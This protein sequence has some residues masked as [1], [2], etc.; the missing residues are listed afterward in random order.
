VNAVEW[1]LELPRRFATHTF[2]V[3]GVTGHTLTYAEYHEAGMGCAGELRRQAVERGDRVVLLLNNSPAF[4]AMYLGCLYVGAVA[5]PVNPVLARP[6]ISFIVRHSR[7]KLAVCS[8]ETSALL[9][10]EDVRAAGARRLVVL[11]GRGP[12]QGSA[13]GAGFDPWSAGSEAGMEPLAGV[14]PEDTMT[15]IYTSGTTGRPSGVV[16]RI[17]DLV[18]NG[19]LFASLVGVDPETR[20]YGILAMAYLGGYYNLLMLPYVAGASVAL[21][22]AFGARAAV[23]FWRPARDSGVNTLWLVPTIM[24]ILLELDRGEEGVHFCREGVR[25]ALVGTAPLP[26][27]LRTAFEERYGLSLLQNYALSETLFLTTDLPGRPVAPGSVGRTIPGVEL[28]ITDESGSVLPAREDGEIEVRT[29]SLFEGYYD[30]AHGRLQ[31][32]ERDSWF[33]TGDIGALDAEGNLFVTGRLKDVIIR[34]GVNVSAAA[35]EDVLHEHASVAECAVV[36]VPHARYGE[37]PVAVVRLADGAS[38]ET[39]ERELA[40][41]CRIRL[42]AMS[43][44]TRIVQVDTLPHSSSGKI[45]K[46]ELRALLA[47]APVDAS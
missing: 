25:L 37:V 42:G 45:Q 14:A 21:V 16:H 46:K 31:A 5:V 32:A 23:D 6:E 40:E 20:L 26:Q 29:P 38:F 24:S 1:L 30:P 19:R 7:A 15:I 2:I 4:A 47:E 3:D 39:V 43:R 27:P 9:E 10:L 12:G 33:P 35:V 44:P 41:L 17:A 22:D 34:G 13:S 28:R 36:G 8:P 11:D 18:D